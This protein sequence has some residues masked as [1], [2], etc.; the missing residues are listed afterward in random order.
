M[1][2][3]GSKADIG[4]GTTHVRFTPNIALGDWNVRFVPKADIDLVIGC[5]VG[6]API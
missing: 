5:A 3:F 1:V 2:C 4:E 6:T